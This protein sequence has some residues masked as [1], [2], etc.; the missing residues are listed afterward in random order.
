MILK[1]RF[2]SLAVNLPHR[3]RLLPRQVRQDMVQ[4]AALNRG[5]SSKWDIDDTPSEKEK[6]KE[7]K[8][9]RDWIIFHWII[10]L[11]IHTSCRVWFN[12]ESISCYCNLSSFYLIDVCLTIASWSTFLHLRRVSHAVVKFLEISERFGILYYWLQLNYQTE[13]L[14][15]F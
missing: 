1:T 7:R 6:E 3:T 12:I 8:K 5:L 14:K 13:I 4:T 15:W 10:F 2:S 9:E 11:D